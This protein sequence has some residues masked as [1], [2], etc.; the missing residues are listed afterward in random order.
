MNDAQTMTNA[1]GGITVK[2]AARVL[3]SAARTFSNCP[4]GCTWE[5]F[6]SLECIRDLLHCES[7]L[8]MLCWLQQELLK[9]GI[10]INHILTGNIKKDIVTIKKILKQ[11][12]NN[13]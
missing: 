1:M 3:E 5:H 13:D 8:A 6:E 9:P 2:E 11:S 4:Y 7:W 12:G 10:N